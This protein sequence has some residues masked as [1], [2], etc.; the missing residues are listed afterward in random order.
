MSNWIKKGISVVKVSDLDKV[1]TVEKAVYKS[2]RIVTSEGEKNVNRIIGIE[3]KTSEG[4]EMCHTKELIPLSVSIKGKLEAY[5][6]I[7][8]EGEYKDY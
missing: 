5:K 3:C 8:R 1:M 2:K 4:K 6:F 7:N